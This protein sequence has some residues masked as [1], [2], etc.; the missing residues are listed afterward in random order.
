MIAV[1]LPPPL[2]RPSRLPHLAERLVDRGVT[3]IRPETG[4]DET[5]PHAARYVA[6]ASMEINRLVAAA[7]PV[8]LVGEGDAGPL[9]GAVGAAQRAAH[10][11]VFGYVLV[12]ALLPQP[13]S[14]TRAE[15]ERAQSPEGAV[16]DGGEGRRSDEP[17]AYRSERLPMVADW[18]DAPCGYLL[19]DPSRAHVA[20]LARMRGWTVRETAPEEAAEA[21]RELLTEL[22][23]TG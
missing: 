19:T 5:P 22:R 6:R 16:G 1:L 2:G 12:D 20:R 14:P 21:L 10:R 11:P 3:P 15:L 23:G 7:S 18:P 13:G 8:A 9:V 17:S 4:G